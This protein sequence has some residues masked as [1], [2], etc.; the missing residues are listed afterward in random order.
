MC[1]TSISNIQVNLWLFFFLLF[2]VYCNSHVPKSGP[3]HLDQTSVGIRQALNVPKSTNYVNE[4]IRGGIKG[5]FEGKFQWKV[6]QIILKSIF[7]QCHIRHQL[8]QIILI[9]KLSV[10]EIPIKM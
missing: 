9:K 5:D 6:T 3:G 2:Q 1:K 7:Q 4:Q 8:N 10:H